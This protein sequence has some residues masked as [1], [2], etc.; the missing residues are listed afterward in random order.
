M[1]PLQAF[2]HPKRAS[3]TIGELTEESNALLSRLAELEADTLRHQQAREEAEKEQERLRAQLL[4][5]QRSNEALMKQLLDTRTGLEG[6]IHSLQEELDRAK[7][8]EGELEEINRQI[9]RMTLSQKNYRARIAAL[10]EELAETRAKL[11]GRPAPSS[12]LPI[13]MGELAPTPPSRRAPSDTGVPPGYLNSA[14]RPVSS[15]PE[16]DTDWLLPLP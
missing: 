11:S 9:E 14:P 4:E 3:R 15:N 16:G 7:I 2:F 1:K 6:R 10:K 5:N 13:D 12:R 8:D